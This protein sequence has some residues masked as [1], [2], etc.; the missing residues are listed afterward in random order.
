MLFMAPFFVSFSPHANR[1][2]AEEDGGS[3]YLK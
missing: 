3:P 1:D 2:E